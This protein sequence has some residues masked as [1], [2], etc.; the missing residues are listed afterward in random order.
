MR[1]PADECGLIGGLLVRRRTPGDGWG[2]CISCAARPMQTPE[3]ATKVE[4][5]QVAAGPLIRTWSA[6]ACA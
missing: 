6:P 5:E 2:R 1:T 4:L 3:R